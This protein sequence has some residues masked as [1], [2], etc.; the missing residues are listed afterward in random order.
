MLETFTDA[1]ASRRSFRPTR[2]KYF[3][4]LRS[5]SHA[6]FPGL[7]CKHM[8]VRVCA[9]QL[10]VLRDVRVC[11]VWFASIKI[12]EGRLF[13]LDVVKPVQLSLMASEDILNFLKLSQ[14]SSVARCTFEVGN[15]YPTH[16]RPPFM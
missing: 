10:H 9:A 7:R 3:R 6:Y 8:R 2:H 11:E 13:S 14:S 15:Y 16:L 12:C 5:D 1:Q 4:A